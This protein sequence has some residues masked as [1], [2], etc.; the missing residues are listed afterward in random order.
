MACQIRA[1][2]TRE[3]TQ[4]VLASMPNNEAIRKMIRRHR[5][6]IAAP[7]PVPIDLVQLNIP[8]QFR[9][10]AIPPDQN[11]LFLLS[12]SGVYMETNSPKR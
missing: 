4:A 10:I 8:D 5:N 2:A 9:Y 7:L 6:E 1:T 12:D 3:T 11:E